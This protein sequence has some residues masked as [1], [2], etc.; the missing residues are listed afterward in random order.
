[1][2]VRAYIAPTAS[3]KLTQK[4]G[5]NSPKARERKISIKS[6]DNDVE[7]RGSGV[8][9]R[10]SRTSAIADEFERRA[11]HFEDLMQEKGDVHVLA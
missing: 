6:I 8:L 2:P 7:I 4:N 5:P 9:A 11:H 3:L 1:M 10:K